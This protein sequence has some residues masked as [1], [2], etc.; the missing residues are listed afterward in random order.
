ML[1]GI[2]EMFREEALLLLR[3][4]AYARSPLSLDELAKATVINPTGKGSVDVDNRGDWEETL[5]V[6]SG[7]VAVERIDNADQGDEMSSETGASYSDDEKPETGGL[8]FDGED[9]ATGDLHFNDGD[10]SADTDRRINRNTKVRLAHYSVKE[11]LESK[12]ILQS[13][14]KNF[15]L[16]SAKEQRFLAQSCLIYILHYSSNISDKTSTKQDLVAFPLLSYA[17]KS[18]FHHSTLQQ[19]GKVS[20]EKFLLSSKEAKLDCLL[21]YLP[22]QPWKIPF[23]GLD[24]AGSGLYYASVVGLDA[25][26]DEFVKCGADVNDQSGFY[27]NALQA[28]S[29]HGH[30]KIVQMLIECGTKVHASGGKYGGALEL[31][32]RQG[33]ENIVQMLIKSST[34]GHAQEMN[35]ND[36]LEEASAQGYEEVVQVLLEAH[37]EVDGPEVDCSTALQIAS[38]KGYE[39]VV[40]MLIDN[41]AEVNGQEGDRG[42]ALQAASYEGHE[43]AVQIILDSGADVNNQGGIF[44]TELKAASLRGH[45]KIVQVLIARGS[46]SDNCASVQADD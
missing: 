36:A 8:N 19:C 9:S 37:A 34:E 4:V 30:E 29:R 12:R 24:D 43:K 44:G 5:N 25:V 41:G 15:Y 39:K 26:V 28:A 42:A 10:L 16:E 27:G 18:W 7:L 38:W 33:Y 40:Q 21:I 13:N 32:S 23:E 22:D 46:L 14:A 2:D 6:L 11:Y 45:E 35:F 20:R 1:T 17:A 3:W 31:A